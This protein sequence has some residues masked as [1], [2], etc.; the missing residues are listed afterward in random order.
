MF[1][2]CNTTSTTSTTNQPINFSTIRYEDCR[3]Q[4][5]NNNTIIINTPGRYYVSFHGVG[6]SD[7]ANGQ[8]TVQL[9]NNGVA[10]PGIVTTISTSVAIA[11]ETLAAATIVNVLPSCTAI[12]NN[13]SLQFVATS[14]DAGTLTSA[15][16]VIFRLK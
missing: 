11:P 6:A 4:L 8:F 3:V 9:Y 2:A 10:V 1:E 5:R 15:N 7:T 14:T 12:C 16:V 13:A